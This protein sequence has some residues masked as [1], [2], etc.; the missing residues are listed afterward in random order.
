M[1]SAILN[2]TE[3]IKPISDFR[4]NTAA[5][6]KQIQESGRPLVLTQHG[7][8]AAILVDVKSYQGMIEELETLREFAA[9]RSEHASGKTSNHSE[10]MDRLRERRS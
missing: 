2:L 6:L 1:S 10:L 7:R 5:L 3:D 4:A 8:S 9:A